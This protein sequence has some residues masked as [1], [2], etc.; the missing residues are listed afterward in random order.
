MSKLKILLKNLFAVIKNH[1]SFLFEMIDEIAILG[2]TSFV[3]FLVFSAKE[4]GMRSV[5]EIS[6]DDV[7]LFYC[8]AV[9]AMIGVS[10]ILHLSRMVFKDKEEKNKPV[11]YKWKEEIVAVIILL[12]CF[13]IFIFITDQFFS[14]GY[15]IPALPK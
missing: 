1:K 5:R 13:F 6:P 15:T 9:T 14:P 3:L 10:I 4:Q 12:I 11:K 7:F 8:M 2:L